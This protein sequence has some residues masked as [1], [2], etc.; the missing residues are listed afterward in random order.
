MSH[1]CPECFTEVF[2]VL[3]DGPQLGTV[4]TIPAMASRGPGR[5]GHCGARQSGLAH[6]AS[7]GPAPGPGAEAGCGLVISVRPA[8]GQA[9]GRTTL[10]SPT[11]PWK[12]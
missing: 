7:A 9:P 10:M 2:S 4:H 6:G 5:E 12:A 3:G 11:E 1:G 8:D